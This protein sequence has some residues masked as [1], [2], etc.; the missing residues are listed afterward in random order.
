M[1]ELRVLVTTDNHLGFAERDHIRGE[2]SFRA[3]E[4]VFKHARETRAD[5]IL[6]CGDL[7]HEVSPSKYTMYRTMEILQRNILG[8]APITME[9]IDNGNFVDIQKKRRETNYYSRNINIELPVFAINGN[10][11]EPS[12]HKGVTALD[13]FAE[14]GLINYFGGMDGK[15]S[16]K[17]IRPLVFKKKGVF[18][19][20]YGMGGIRDETMAKLLAEE[21][22]AFEMAPGGLN[23]LVLHQT[24]CGV[25]NHLYVP[26]DLLS[27]EMDL[28]VW[29]HMH[30]SEPVP[31]ENLKMGFHTIQP[32]STVQTSLC[33]AESGDKHCILLKVTSNGW[34]TV[35]LLMES[36]RSL[37]FR[38]M[39]AAGGALEERIR[40]EM[41]SILA[42]HQDRRRPLVRLRVEVDS[43]SGTVI[44]KRIM[45]E[46]KDKVANPKDVLRVIHR[47]KQAALEKKEEAREV[48]RS[49]QFVVDIED[50]KILPKGVFMQGIM[51]CIEKESKTA[52]SRRYDEIV[53]EVV[54]V[55]KS[56]RWTDIEKEIPPAVH[57][58]EKRLLYAYDRPYAC[59]AEEAGPGQEK[60]AEASKEQASA[61]DCAGGASSRKEAPSFPEDDMFG[62]AIEEAHPETE[63]AQ[64][65][66]G[67][68]EPGC[69]ISQAGAE[70]APNEMH[71]E[72]EKHLEKE[73][74]RKRI[75]TDFAFS[76]LWD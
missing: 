35:P 34:K 15:V 42:Q 20:L 51:E 19:N 54:K 46:F 49:T 63:K 66:P 65:G 30:K 57:E 60:T 32:G 36:S 27:K 21:R 62:G 40:S 44:P 25:G 1:E 11:D 9:C 72:G 16:S 61:A 10:H 47:K 38:T 24:R 31:V 58:I 5:C 74:P 4:E 73:N 8:D 39:S 41:R 3:F 67:L 23:V 7:F 2:D 29:G 50:A 53:Q 59:R 48:H 33:K 17:T 18:L 12:G 28:V 22:I 68:S 14:A 45:E 6:I 71:S 55:L 13:I 26:E 52:I 43:A 69:Y 76:A 56:H 75:K 70:K 37:V 64:R